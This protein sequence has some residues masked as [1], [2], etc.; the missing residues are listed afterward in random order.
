MSLLRQN[1]LWT[2]FVLVASLWF[3]AIL[4]LFSSYSGIV[5]LWLRSDTYAHG[6]IVLP[7]SLYLVWRI[8]D[9]WQSVAVKPQ[10]LALPLVLG[11]LGAWLLGVIS[12]V[13]ALEHLA[14]ITLL[15]LIVWVVMGDA[16]TRLILFPL[17]FLI[18]AVPIGDFLIDPMMEFTADFT[19]AVIRWFGI[20]V[21][22][23]G[24]Y[25]SLPSGQWSVVKACSGI[26]YIIASLTLGALYSYL[27][28]SRYWKRAIFILFAAIL[29]ILANGIRAVIIVLIGHFSDMELATG[30]DH[31][32]YGWIF[33]GIVIFVMFWIGSFFADVQAKPKA[34]GGQVAADMPVI[35]Q[36]AWGV[37]VFALILGFRLWQADV[38]TISEKAKLPELVLPQ[39][40]GQWH[41]DTSLLEN[42]EPKYFNPAQTIQAS[43]RS[44]ADRVGLYLAYFPYQNANSELT[45]SLNDLA[46]K[47]HQWRIIGKSTQQINGFEVIETV[48]QRKEDKW[49]MWSWYQTSQGATANRVTAKLYETWGI[50]AGG[51]SAGAGIV[52]YHKM[53]QNESTTRNILTEFM[54]EFASPLTQLPA[55]R[56]FD[57]VEKDSRSMD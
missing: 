9:R 40:I 12:G 8:R 48:L 23:E 30:A 16:F 54:N 56:L 7:I 27:T 29:P 24:L 38:Q 35:N 26:R 55:D 37:A 18:F 22:R 20:P 39:N 51:G 6:F 44:D 5:D 17:C 57:Q 28:Y 4:L 25:F 50:L 32:I 11:C 14:A 15:P 53:G 46:G 31:L 45:S 21:Y 19:V 3:A 10:P 41:L 42:W 13:Q 34:R 1:R 49:L 52:V 2:G 36:V 43:Y 33:F 47:E